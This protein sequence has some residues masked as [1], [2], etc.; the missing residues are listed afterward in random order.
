MTESDRLVNKLYEVMLHYN[1]IIALEES[2]TGMISFRQSALFRYIEFNHRLFVNIHKIS[3]LCSYEA[4][5]HCNYV[6]L[7]LPVVVSSRNAK[8]KY[9]CYQ[10]ITIVIMPS[11]CISSKRI[12]Y[13]YY[14]AIWSALVL[15]LRG[16]IISSALSASFSFSCCPVLL[17]IFGLIVTL[18]VQL[19]VL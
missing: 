8:T 9:I 19:F 18:F 5:S 2:T 11:C 17:N 15:S 10:I 16:D 4:Y 14:A 7:R 6:L 3:E 12:K 1:Y 13:N